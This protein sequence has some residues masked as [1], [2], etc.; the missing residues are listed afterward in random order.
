MGLDKKGVC[1]RMQKNGEGFVKM[2]CTYADISGHIP[3]HWSKYSLL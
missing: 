2:A 1:G 3:E